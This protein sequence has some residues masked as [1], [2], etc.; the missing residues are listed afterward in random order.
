MTKPPIASAVWS[1]EPVSGSGELEVARIAGRQRSLIQRRQLLAAGISRSTI[2][3]RLE[4]KRLF[5]TGHRTVYLV[6]RPTF[7]PLGPETA[8]ILHFGGEAVISHRSAALL[9][10]MLDSGSAR[11]A[12]G[13]VSVTIVGRSAHSRPELQVHRISDLD[14]ADLRR[15]RGLPVTSPARTLLDNAATLSSLELENALAECRRRNLVRDNQI[16][17]AM[18]RAPGR[19]GIERLRKLIDNSTDPAR[20][21]SG[22]ERTLIHLVR[23]AGLPEPVANLTVCGHMV[24]LIWPAQKLVVEF[25]GWETHGTRAAFETDRRRDQRLVAAGY[26]VIRITYRQLTDEPYAVIARLTAALIAIP[27]VIQS[28]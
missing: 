27:T 15:Y 5:A 24:D 12:I 17:A 26:R 8:A 22:M 6:G 18:E 20:T 7:E 10:G 23:A 28:A 3:R 14:L 13:G 25:D 4:T 16:R 1:P 21:R 2:Q 9:W 11:G 19:A